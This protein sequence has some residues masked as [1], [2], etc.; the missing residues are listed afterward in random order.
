MVSSKEKK[1]TKLLQENVKKY[2][3]V[4]QRKWGRWVAEIRDVR[5]NK[6]RWLGSFN[7]ALE[8]ALAY[9]KAAIEIKGANAV[10]NIIEPPPKES[11]P[12]HQ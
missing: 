11:H 10:T 5:M 7:T 9:D 1:D 2:R 8:A 6:R 3:G 12:I 4:R